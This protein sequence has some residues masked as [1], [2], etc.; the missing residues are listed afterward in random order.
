M[1]PE[2]TGWWGGVGRGSARVQLTCQS[3]TAGGDEHG[4]EHPRRGRSVL[5]H[6]DADEH[7]DQGQAALEDHV[8]G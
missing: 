2:V 7:G 1:I 4:R 5:E 8:H 6:Q 3:R